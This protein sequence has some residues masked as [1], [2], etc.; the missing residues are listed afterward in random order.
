MIDQSF[1]VVYST[2]CASAPIYGILRK[3]KYYQ[4]ERY[5]RLRSGVQF[6]NSVPYGLQAQCR[7]TIVRLLKKTSCRLRYLSLDLAS[8]DTPGLLKNSPG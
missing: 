4:D 7:R 2:F 6:C 3:C 8:G 1:H 5:T